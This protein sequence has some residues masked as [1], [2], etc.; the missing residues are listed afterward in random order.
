MIYKV[1]QVI[2]EEVN[3]YFE[4]NPVSLENIA[5]VMDS[6]GSDNQ[7]TA[8]DIVLSLLNMQEE[9]AMKNIPN[10]Y[11]NGTT[12]EYKNHRVNLNL[13]VLFSATNSIYIEALKGISKIIEFFQGKNV[14]TQ[15]NSNFLREGEM[16]DVG[17]FRFSIAL[18][19]PTF[20]ELNF[21]WGTLGGKQYPSVLYKI[22]LIELERNDVIVESGSLITEIDNQLKNIES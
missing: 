10:N 19:T 20:E 11:T 8:T 9:F 14:F 5:T 3:S 22:S 7:N 12:V 13:Y 1:L 18:Y 17:D 15:A 21:I 4:G 6:D 16:L 2:T